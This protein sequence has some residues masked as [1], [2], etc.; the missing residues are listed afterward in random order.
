MSLDEQ[1]WRMKRFQEE[2]NNFNEQLQISIK[3]VEAKYDN[4]NFVWQD[5]VRLKHDQEYL[6]SSEW[7]KHY[8]TKKGPQCVEFLSNKL[9]VLERY[10]RGG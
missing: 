4:L 3:E 9:Q 6:P 8:I 10:L 7:L 2:L 1:Y 5:E